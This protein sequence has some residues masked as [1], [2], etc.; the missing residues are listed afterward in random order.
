M[1]SI[2]TNKQGGVI[3]WDSSDWLQGLAPQWN[4]DSNEYLGVADIPGLSFSIGMNPFRR[5]GYLYPGFSPTDVTNVAQVDSALLNIAYADDGG[6]DNF[7]YAGGGTKVMAVNAQTLAIVTSNPSVNTITAAGSHGAHISIDFKDIVT[8]SVNGTKA[9]FYSWS[10]DTD[11]DVGKIDITS[12][13][14]A[15]DDDWLSTTPASGAALTTTSDHPLI[16]GADDI[17]YIGDG[18]DLHGLD[19]GTGANGTFNSQV[20]RL[21]QNMRIKGFAKTQNYLVI[22]ADDTSIGV[23][24][25][26]RAESK[27]F[28]WDYLSEDPTFVYDI[29]ANKVGGAFTFK[30]TIGCFG[31][32]RRYANELKNRMFIFDGSQFE[33]VAEF[34][35]NIP[36]VGGVEIISNAVFF[37]AGGHLHMYGNPFTRGNQFNRVTLG[38]GTTSGLVKLMSNGNMLMSSGTT[39]SGGLQKVTNTGNYEATSQAVTPLTEPGFP[40][41]FMGRV[42]EV[43]VHWLKA[44][45]SAGNDISISLNTNGGATQTTVV[46]AIT[47]VPQTMS[48]YVKADSGSFPKFSSIG[49]DVVYTADSG[50]GNEPPIVKA[51]EVYYQNEKI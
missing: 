6:A 47:T 40:P 33:V 38:A 46:N 20:L 4:T 24:S 8:Y 5:Q 16:V 48:T 27:A 26:Y 29:P 11:G 28:F 25:F 17:M 39:T 36:V 18:R 35:G 21:P 10:D 49:L 3:R 13:A 50:V 51:V 22:F 30:N 31:E 32:Q 34:A 45:S 9:V 41:N 1:A 43:K 7:A 37:N 14:Q 12:A 42:T 44:I 19:G 2:S 23:S 15:F